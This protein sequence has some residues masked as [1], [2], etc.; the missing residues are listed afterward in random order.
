MKDFR[1]PCIAVIA[2]A[3]WLGSGSV[4]EAQSPI[5]IGATLAQTGVYA[6]PA[7]NQ[8]RG[9]KLCVKH[10]NGKGGMLGRRLELVLYDDG[11][12]PATAARLYEK[13]IAED[14]VDLVLGP[15]GSPTSEAVAD[16]NEKYRMPMVAPVAATTS[17]YKKGRR[18]IFSMLPPAEVYLEGLIDIAVKMRLKTAAMINADELFARAAAQGTIELAKSRG[19][20]SSS[21]TRTPW[22]TPTSRRS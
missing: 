15:Y 2:L 1:R 6:V 20:S 13:L 10:V 16:V 11:S 21:P 12:K 14:R 7:Q 17:I 19:F 5:R 8:L 18:F 3:L 4:A 9:Y 22:G